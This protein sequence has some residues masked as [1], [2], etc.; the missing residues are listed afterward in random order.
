MFMC[1]V[2]GSPVVVQAVVE[3]S[4]AGGGEKMAPANGAGAMP[5]VGDSAVLATPPREE[6]FQAL[7][8]DMM[9][10]SAERAANDV[11]WRVFAARGQAAAAAERDATF[12][13]VFAAQKQAAAKR[14]AERAAAAAKREAT[15]EAQRRRDKRA[16]A[17]AAEQRAAK[18]KITSKTETE[19]P[20][21]ALPV[22]SPAPGPETELPSPA[23]PNAD[24]G[25]LTLVQPAP[26]APTPVTAPTHPGGQIAV[27][28]PNPTLP[29]DLQPKCAAYGV[30][31]EGH[32][33][34]AVQHCANALASRPPPILDRG[35]LAALAEQHCANAVVP[36]PPPLRDRGW[37]ER[38]CAVAQ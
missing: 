17:A 12:W 36:R 11:F 3:Q 32:A 29:Q 9:R 18:P 13:R 7:I 1:S 34:G 26:S 6:T 14:S 33:A 19:L 38:L 37:R 24:G 25:E 22:L 2:R 16:A 4:L 15:F 30:G 8:E 21:P 28:Q 35:H 20:S 31:R 10:F 5:T 23:L 27:P